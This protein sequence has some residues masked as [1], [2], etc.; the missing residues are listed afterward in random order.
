MALLKEVTHALA[1]YLI[2][3][4][5]D[6]IQVETNPEKDTGYKKHDF[7]IGH[8][9]NRI[10]TD[11]ELLKFENRDIMDTV[12]LMIHETVSKLNKN[13]VFEKGE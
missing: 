8:L 10:K 3:L 9:A 6:I 5:L 13:G 2:D 12:N 7:V 11:P 4:V 1:S